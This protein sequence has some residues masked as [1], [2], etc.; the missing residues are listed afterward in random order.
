[1]F[2][3]KDTVSGNGFL[4]AVTLSGR[5]LIV[6]EDGKWWVNGVRPGAITENGDTPEEAFLRFRNAYKNLLFDFAEEAVTFASFKEMAERFYQQPDPEEEDNWL[7]AF[8]ALRSGEVTPEE[9]FSKLPKEDPA[10][11]PPSMAVEKLDAENA[12]YTPTDNVPDYVS[13][14]KAMPK[15]A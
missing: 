6:Q 2:T 5:A 4:A 8:H 9:P 10:K 11:R 13:M 15:A 12:R 3:L 14:P 7:A 1:M